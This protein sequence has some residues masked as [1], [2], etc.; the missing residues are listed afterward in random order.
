M[1]KCSV[2]L[3]YCYDNNVREE[4]SIRRVFKRS[5]AGVGS[6]IFKGMGSTDTKILLPPSPPPLA[7]LENLV[8]TFC[9]GFIPVVMPFQYTGEV[10]IRRVLERSLGYGGFQ[11]GEEYEDTPFLPPPLGR[12]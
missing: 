10:R 8:K 9:C 11:R 3:S 12:T 4:V 2:V 7:I 6:F 5:L 1:E